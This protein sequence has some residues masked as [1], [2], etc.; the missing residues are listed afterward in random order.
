L[1][2]V[3]VAQL[4]KAGEI[5]MNDLNR[6]KMDG[7]SNVPEVV[8][9]TRLVT[10]QLWGIETE[11]GENVVGRFRAKWVKMRQAEWEVCHVA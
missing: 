2:G 11:I 9:I 1:N 10:I 5:E 3:S 4:T 8:V 6:M 7:R